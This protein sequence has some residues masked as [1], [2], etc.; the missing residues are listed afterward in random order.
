MKYIN[1]WYRFIVL[2]LI[3]APSSGSTFSQNIYYANASSLFK[4]VT[5]DSSI[6]L[7]SANNQITSLRQYKHSIIFSDKNGIYSYDLINETQQDVLD[8]PYVACMCV[9]EYGVIYAYNYND[10]SLFSYNLN[11]SQLSVI[12]KV[13]SY[14]RDIDVCSSD[15]LLILRSYSELYTLSLIDLTKKNITGLAGTE[16]AFDPGSRNLFFDLTTYFMDGSSTEGIASYCIDEDPFWINYTFILN[17]HNVHD[18]YVT[19]DKLYWLDF[20]TI[21]NLGRIVSSNFDGTEIDTVIK[22]SSADKILIEKEV[23]SD[24]YYTD[25]KYNMYPNPTNGMV[26]LSGFPEENMDIKVYSAGGYLMDVFEMNHG[27][28]DISHLPD[29]LY[30]I[31]IISEK[32]AFQKRIIKISR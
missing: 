19:P 4:Y 13:E 20:R 1:H 31:K 14:I 8:G 27:S 28:F 22:A 7:T 17:I 23:I 16:L 10:S 11:N 24:I 26:N 5:A 29:G 18:I 6:R 32:N 21:E 12:T 30:I 9:D 25:H 15:N 2:L 3:I